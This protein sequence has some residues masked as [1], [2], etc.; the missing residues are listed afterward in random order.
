MTDPMER[1]TGGEQAGV[2]R[3]PNSRDEPLEPTRGHFGQG[4]VK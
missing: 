4:G 3:P 1:D 2:R